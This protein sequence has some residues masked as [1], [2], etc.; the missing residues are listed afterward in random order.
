MPIST[1]PVIRPGV[2]VGPNSLGV[3]ERDMTAEDVQISY[4]RIKTL[5]QSN[6]FGFIGLF[7]VGGKKKPAY[8]AFRRLPH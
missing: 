6:A 5:P 4:E 8:N 3:P 2:K 1:R 7:T